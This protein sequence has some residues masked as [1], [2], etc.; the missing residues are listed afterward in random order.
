MGYVLIFNVFVMTSSNGSIFRV[1]GPLCA[2]FT[3][4]R[5]IP[6]TKGHSR[7]TLVFYLICAWT[8]GWV[9]N[10]CIGYLKRHRA[11]YDIIVMGVQSSFVTP[12][13]TTNDDWAFNNSHECMPACSLSGVL[14]FVT[15]D[16]CFNTNQM[17]NHLD[18]IRMIIANK[19]QVPINDKFLTPLFLMV[20]SSSRHNRHYSCKWLLFSWQGFC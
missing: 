10:R 6:R 5:W 1:T 17:C 2:E 15:H 11:H 16:I 8:N 20:T 19:C 3:G 14:I 9:N 13:W 4:D 7:G 18:C 12:N